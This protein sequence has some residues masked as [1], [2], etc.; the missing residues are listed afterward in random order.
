MSRYILRRL[1][2]TPVPLL[3]IT[4]VVFI[5]MHVSGDPVQ[6]MLGLEATP[7]QVEALREKLGLNDPVVVQY[8]RFLLHAAQGDF[9]ESLRFRQGALELVL[10]RFPNTLL[11][12]STALV[13]AVMVGITLGVIAAQKRGSLLDLSLVSVS[14]FGQSMPSFW[15]G[16]MLVIFFSVR[17]QILP[18]SGTGSWKHIVLPAI[19]LALYMLPQI[20]LL[21]RSTMLDVLQETYM[22]VAR[23][24][25]LRS[26]TV[27]YGHALKNAV[28]P[29]VTYIGLQ[30][31]ILLGGSIIVESVFSY[32]GVGL[33]MV[34]SIYNRDTP[35]VEAAVVFMAV[36]IILSNLLADIINALLD[37][38][39]RMT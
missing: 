17:L 39:I 33:L 14:V 36:A 24:K 31:G 9:G 8:G 35:V 32:P 28:H 18:S 27:I 3:L 16:I 20:A 11:L 25:G 13:L 1:A 23:A 2:Q 12:A 21:T 34:Q 30:F 5:I 7:D 29:V 22:T 10:A 19:T 4:M 38:R 37:P 15:I 26:R 6:L